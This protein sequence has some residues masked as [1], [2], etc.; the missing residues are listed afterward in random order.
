M[1]NIKIRKI[2]SKWFWGW[3]G[4]SVVLVIAMFIVGDNQ[5]A[6]NGLSA[7]IMAL[8]MVMPVA[9]WLNRFIMWAIN[10]VSSIDTKFKDRIN[11]YAT[12][13]TLTDPG[14]RQENIGFNRLVQFF[15]GIT[16]LILALLWLVF[17]H[18]SFEVV[19][20]F[21]HTVEFIITRKISWLALLVEVLITV[22]YCYAVFNFIRL[23]L[24]GDFH[25][26]DGSINWTD[27]WYKILLAVIVFYI[28][29]VVSALLLKYTA[30][31]VGASLVFWTTTI[32]I[33]LLIFEIVGYVRR[34]RIEASNS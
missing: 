22:A 31:M 19:Y 8:F 14:H 6:L 28:K 2:F 9:S 21:L 20:S 5:K 18:M 15:C 12:Y 29:I 11:P 32:G 27:S 26:E 4:I 33:P 30:E 23:I 3:F 24:N 7:A 16:A 13:N 17:Q 34:R 1:N 25:N 10:F